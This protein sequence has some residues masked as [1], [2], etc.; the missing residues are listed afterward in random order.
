MAKECEY[1]GKKIPKTRLDVLPETT[2]C[3]ACSVEKGYIGVISA[4]ER[5]DGTDI[6]ISKPDSSDP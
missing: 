4:G 6:K 5:L 3:V 1:C 2:T